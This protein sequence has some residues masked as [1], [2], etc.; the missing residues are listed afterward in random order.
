MR[1]IGVSGR[2]DRRL[3]DS[4]AP[5]GQR[6]RPGG[7]GRD[8]PDLLRGRPARRRGA[9][10]PPAARRRARAA[11]ARRRA[12][13]SGGV[14]LW[15]PG[16]REPT[17]GVRAE[18]LASLANAGPRVVTAMEADRL[19]E[20]TRLD[21]LTGLL[22][23]R[24]LDAVLN[25]VDVGDGAVIYAD[26]DKFKDL[27]DKLG[28]PAGDAALMHFAR[29][30]REQVRNG[31]VGRGSAG[32]SSPSG[33]RPRGW[34]WATGS[35]SGSGS[36]STRP[37]GTGGGGP[38]R[39]ARRSAWP[40]VRRPAGRSGISSRRRMRRCTWRRTAGGTGWSGRGGGRRRAVERSGGQAA[41][42]GDQAVTIKHVK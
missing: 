9:G 26:L 2:G 33:C 27:N 32:R 28:H 12:H 36:S 1:V 41:A 40:P 19:K 29:I 7:P 10:P 38:G 17:G 6:S 35:P 13:T 39:S 15:P 18:I 37:H 25:R 11:D 8:G 21:P 24:G 14:A 3:L 20:K 22:N 5:A 31:D 34:T 23:R 4:R 30:I 42:S 16:G